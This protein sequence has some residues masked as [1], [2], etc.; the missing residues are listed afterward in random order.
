MF[1]LMGRIQ[2]PEKTYPDPDPD[3]QKPPDKVC[4]DLIYADAATTLRR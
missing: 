3:G 1:K 4:L 2:D